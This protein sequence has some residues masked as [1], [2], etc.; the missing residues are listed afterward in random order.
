MKDKLN[1]KV[2]G[3]EPPFRYYCHNDESSKSSE[4]IENGVFATEYVNTY[5]ELSD[6]DNE[7]QDSLA[8]RGATPGNSKN[9]E[10]HKETKENEREKAGTAA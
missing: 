6:F 10:E 8:D 9:K 7:C 5:V 1:F 2:N 4:N 3:R